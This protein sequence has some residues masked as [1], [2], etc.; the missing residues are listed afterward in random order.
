MIGLDTLGKETTS[1]KRKRT[2]NIQYRLYDC[3]KEENIIIESSCMADAYDKA[4]FEAIP[5]FK[6]C[7]PY[8]A[9]VESVMLKNGKIK[10]F[11]TCEGDPY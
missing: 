8:S 11:N 7:T 4:V 9:W 2:Y 6:G 10:R 5:A 3:S 1:K